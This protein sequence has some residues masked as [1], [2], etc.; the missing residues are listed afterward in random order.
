MFGFGAALSMIG[1]MGKVA[2]QFSAATDADRMRKGRF[3]TAQGEIDQ[4]YN[5]M[6]DTAS[7]RTRD[8]SM[9][10]MFSLANSGSGTSAGNASATRAAML[11]APGATGQADLAASQIAS[12]Y[13]GQVQN[14]QGLQLREDAMDHNNIWSNVE[15]GFDS[16][17]KMGGGM[18]GGAM[19]SDERA[20]QPVGNAQAASAGGI[21]PGSIGPTS[22]SWM[23]SKNG[24]NVYQ[25]A[26][27]ANGKRAPVDARAPYRTRYVAMGGPDDFDGSAVAVVGQPQFSEEEAANLAGEN[28]DE[29]VPLSEADWMRYQQGG[30]RYDDLMYEEGKRPEQLHPAP[31]GF[32]ERSRLESESLQR[33]VGPMDANGRAPLGGK[34]GAPVK[35]SRYPE[36]RQAMGYPSGQ[37]MVAVTGPEASGMG[38]RGYPTRESATAR[39]S[40]GMAGNYPLP[41]PAEAGHLSAWGASG[42]RIPFSGLDQDTGLMKTGAASPGASVDMVR[43]A[44]NSIWEYKPEFQGQPGTAPGPQVGPMAQDLE[45]TPAGRVAVKTGPDGLKRV[46]PARVAMQTVGAVH[47]IDARLRRLEGR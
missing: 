14:A 42:T 41:T 24:Q 15:G 28:Y 4:T 16:L 39:E 3:G 6:F 30:R 20:K 26:L 40:A 2:S 21:R 17:G 36:I 19:L 32:D 46:D 13:S 34:G 1:A 33:G 18:E 47:D 10:N 29:I 9:N 7:Q 23:D 45:K 43:Q 11:Q 27:V 44:P 31:S 35:A 22:T 8:A 37:P 38:Q 5:P 25:G 12:D